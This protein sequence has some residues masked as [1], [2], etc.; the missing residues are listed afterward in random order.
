MA[1]NRTMRMCA[2]FKRGVPVKEIAE[3][4]GVLNPAVY[5]ALRRGG[6]LPPYAKKD[7]G[8]PGRPIG[9]G[10]SGYTAAR[11]TRSVAHISK[12]EARRPSADVPRVDRDPC[13]MCGTRADL[14][15]KHSREP[16]PA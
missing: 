6:V 2:A 8:G 7:A 15:C 9:G 16:A 4:F 5:K 13:F 11:L 10:T 1:E 14:G 12:Q 3:T